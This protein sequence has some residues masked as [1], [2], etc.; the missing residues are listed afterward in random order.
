MMLRTLVAVNL[1]FSQVCSTVV[2]TSLSDAVGDAIIVRSEGSTPSSSLS[3]IL[4]R[5][6][7]GDLRKWCMGEVL[8]ADN[9]EVLDS[10][11]DSPLG[12]AE[13]LIYTLSH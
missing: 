8:L 7:C 12:D 6:F 10:L 11:D 3:D 9:S 13:Y 1:I 2:S 5:T 4:T